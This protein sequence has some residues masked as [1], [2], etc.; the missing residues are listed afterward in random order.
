MGLNTP[1]KTTC[2]IPVVPEVPAQKVASLLPA[3]ASLFLELVLLR[4]GH[5][6]SVGTPGPERGT[7]E[8]GQ[9]AAVCS[10]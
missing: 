10:V 5:A 1:F 2:P 9:G 7:P 8:D 3:H 4:A 6:T